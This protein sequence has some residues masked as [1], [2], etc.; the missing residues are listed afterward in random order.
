MG[1]NKWGGGA[2][3]FQNNHK[4]GLNKWGG[5]SNILLK[6]DEKRAK[7]PKKG[8]FLKTLKIIFVKKS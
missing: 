7:S 8:T 4:W 3:I 5:G 6:N 1:V 2:N